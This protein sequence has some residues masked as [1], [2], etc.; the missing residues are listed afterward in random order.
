M[1]LRSLGLV[2]GVVFALRAEDPDALFLQARSLPRARRGEARELCL[3]ALR[4][5]PAYDEVRVHLARLYAWDDRYDEARAQLR[6]IL[7]PRPGNLEARDVAIDVEVWSD[8]LPEALRLCHE[9]LALD[10]PRRD[11]AR[12]LW[13]KA[14]VLRRLGDLDGAHGATQAALTLDP[15][16]SEARLLQADLAQ[17]RRRDKVALTYSEDTYSRTFLPWH[18]GSLTYG[19][20]FDPG[21]VLAR[22]TR[23]ERF[24]DRGT[25]VELEGYPHL[26]NHTYAFLNVGRSS[27]FMFPSTSGAAEL[28]H[29]F[30]HG[31]EASL[32]ALFLDF[33]GSKVTVYTGSFG[34]YA[35]DG[36]YGLRLYE[37]PS[38][39]GASLS[40]ALSARWYLSDADSY[41]FL[42]ASD[43]F[44]Q[45]L[46]TWSPQSFTFHTRS[47]SAGLQRLVGRRW[48]WSGSFTWERQEYF[49]AEWQTHLTTTIG[50]EY[51][52]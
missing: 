8:H 31:V 12:L 35:G 17:Q 47:G 9:G 2:A 18:T 37:T 42:K 29:N 6:L 26:F 14:R 50:V 34:V 5:H 21:T 10:L 38:V 45:N 41:V 33:P 23:A 3:R 15:G 4:D 11:A 51:R 40:G 48:V 52:F 19:H 24:S 46:L 7:G 36:L 13:R 39:A 20:H 44:S 32:G 16:L 27:S 43:G 1:N 30:H 22:V 49:P 28:Y 25:Q